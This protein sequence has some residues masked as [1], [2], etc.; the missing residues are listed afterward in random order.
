MN[1]PKR[2]VSKRWLKAMRNRQE[3]ARA[4]LSR[5]QLFKMGLLTSGGYLVAKS[6]LSAWASDGCD[7]GDCRPGCS[8][9]TTPFL[10]PLRV[11]PLLP[12]RAAS[13]LRPAPRE[14]PNNA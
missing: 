5:R 6:G 12:A 3:I 13:E 8:P 2:R 1:L 4:G 9:P 10:D 11:P 14:A 7:S